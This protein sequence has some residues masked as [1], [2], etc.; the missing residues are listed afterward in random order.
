MLHGRRGPGL[1]DYAMRG[2]RTWLREKRRSSAPVLDELG[3][4]FRALYECDSLGLT[5]LTP[6]GR[7]LGANRAFQR[8]LG[9]E[10]SELAKLTF[11]DVTYAEDIPECRI[12]FAE[13]QRSAIDHFEVEKRFIRKNGGILWA[14]V[15]VAGVHEKG[16]LL[17]TIGVTKDITRRKLAEESVRRMTA[18]L[19]E[20]VRQRTSELEYQSALISAEQEASPDG[21]VAVDFDGGRVLSNNIRFA[22]MWSFSPGIGEPGSLDGM[23]DHILAKLA[24]PEI[25]KAHLRRVRLNPGEQTFIE[26]VLADGRTLEVYSRPISGGNGRRYGRVSYFH[27]VTRRARAE[28]QLREKSDALARS[29]VDLDMF[30]YTAA[31]DLNAPLRRVIGFGDLLKESLKDRL[32]AS[33]AELLARM[34][35]SAAGMSKLIT[36]VLTLARVGREPLP[37]EDVDLEALTASVIADLQDELNEAG[38]KIETGRLPVLRAHSVLLRRVLQN[39]IANAIK[40]RRR[41]E[42]LRARVA[43]AVRD[44]VIEISVADNGIG[45]E[46]KDAD[47]VFEP[48]VRLHPAGEYLGS[49]IGLAICRRIAERYGGKISA[50]GEPGGGAVFR[51][52]LPGSMLARP[53]A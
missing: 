31:H 35:T 23:V 26:L 8:M 30:A 13:L 11:N 22:E 51:L 33:A 25:L 18:D 3:R 40:F 32:D 27:D 20:R 1:P 29:N 45:F 52:E 19:E 21:I 48:F 38:A 53:S 12:A 42:P 44:G 9:Y 41:D 34:Q 43:S 17:H 37:P 7:F 39:L 14:H 46:Q 47:K 5:T 6:E 2:L 49:G 36:D 50:V 16:R 15:V 4:G 28:A 10:E 24:D